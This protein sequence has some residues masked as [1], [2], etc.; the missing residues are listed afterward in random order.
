MFEAGFS[1]SIQQIALMALPVVLA[2]TLHEAAHGWVADRFGDSTARREGRLTLNPLAHIDPI[3]TIL[4]PILLYVTTGF[5]IGY[6]KPVPVNFHNLRNPKRDM[7]WV[8]AA[9]PGVNLGLA[10]IFGLLF[11]GIL[12]LQP[13]A[14]VQSGGDGGVGAFLLTPV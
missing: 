4:I 5:V 3:G 6:A 8:A 7:I 11:Q 12:A 9:G 14:V 10:L 13:G 1:Q 2:I